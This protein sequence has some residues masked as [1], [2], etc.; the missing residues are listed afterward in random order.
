MHKAISAALL[1]FA[2][3][4]LSMLGTRVSDQQ[5]DDVL[6]NAYTI[7]NAVVIADHFGKTE[8][9]QGIQSSVSSKG[10]DPNLVLIIISM[11]ERTRLE[12]GDDHR[13]IGEF[14]IVYR[15]GERRVRA[16]VVDYHGR[17]P[18]GVEL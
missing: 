1:E 8:M 11:I 2:D 16:T 3:P 15:D 6:R 7:W 18:T 14:K 10:A 13:I 5:L 12:F 17:N 4:I 9:V